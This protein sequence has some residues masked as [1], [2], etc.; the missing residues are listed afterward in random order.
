MGDYYDLYLKTTVSEKF[1]GLCL[2]Y[3]GLDP[4]HYFSSPGLEWDAMLKMTGVELKLISNIDMY[5]FIDKGVR[6]IFL[7]C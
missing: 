3:Y 5:L 6:G 7:H 2:E 1:T 4:S